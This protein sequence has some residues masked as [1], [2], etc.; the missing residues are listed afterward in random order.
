MTDSNLV[1]ER[2]SKARPDHVAGDGD[3]AQRLRILHVVATG[4]RRGA[5]VFAADLARALSHRH[6]TQHIVVLRSAGSSEV[7]YPVGP[8]VLVEQASS[9]RGADVIRAVRR[10][11]TIVEGW[12]PHLI[13]A[14]GGEPLKYV[15][16]ATVGQARPIVYRR[17]G[18][19]PEW[20][21][22][23]PRRHVQ[24]R[25]MRRAALIVAVAN[26]IRDET[27]RVFDIS[28]ARIRVIP[29]GVDPS[30]LAQSSDRDEVRRRLGILPGSPVVLSVGALTWEK[31]P[32]A[33]MWAAER[34]RERYPNALHLIVGDG[35][36][37]RQLETAMRSVGLNGSLRLLGSRDDVPDLM[38]A[39]DLLLFASRPDGMEGMPGVLI[40]AGMIGLPTAA[41]DVA[42]VSEVIE[43]G[44]T[45][46]LAKP[47]DHEGLAASAI[48]LL[49]EPGTR[50][51]LAAAARER[52]RAVF[53]IDGI[54]SQYLSVYRELSVTR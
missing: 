41:F 10:L 4:T 2:A 46:L 34:I 43:D 39:S 52:C 28:P 32:M 29:N 45:G 38:A 36:M 30:R 7:Q 54:A 49:D 53:G 14:H 27:I 5:E 33:H 6:L 24:R 17:I 35:P 9:P 26:A 15:V 16:A 51:R 19:A 3:G 11:R 50:V 42:G 48:R 37:R 8:S 31:D 40:E 1:R 12:S 13:Q 47:G 22:R 23:G 18:A 20:I 44:V 25:L 21:T